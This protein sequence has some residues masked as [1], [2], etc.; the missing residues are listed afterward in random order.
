MIAVPFVYF[1]LLTFILFRRH[2]RIDLVTLISSMFAISGFFSILIDYYDLRYWD[3][4]GYEITTIPAIAYCL[5]LTMCLVP[6][7]VNSN[8]KLGRFKPIK[9]EKIIEIVAWGSTFWFLTTLAFGWD[10]MMH[11]LTG[12]MGDIRKSITEGGGE[13]DWMLS[14]PPLIRLFLSIFNMIF[15]CSWVLIFLAFF[16][17]YVQR[18]SSKYFYLFIFASLSGPFIGIVG[19]DRSKTAYWII[20]ITGMYLLF[21]K[22]M[23]SKE[24]KGAIKMGI[25]IVSILS[26]YLLM[27]TI[28]RFG[29]RDVGMGIGGTEGGIVSYL[30]QNYINFCYFF[31]N[32]E[33]PFTHLGIIFP[34][35]SQYIFGVPSGGTIIQ[36]EM[37]FL[38]HHQTNVFYTFLGHVII[39][40]GKWVAIIFA[41]VY[42]ILS[43]MTLP[44]I[45]RNR[46]VKIS[47]LYLYFAL[48]SVLLLG[49]F[50]HYYTSSILTFS[51]LS[52]FVVVK[53]MEKA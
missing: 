30:G 14:L 15:G 44:K 48:I 32:Y 12:N 19:A 28:S 8:L 34:F 6:F 31:D 29:E 7:V 51:L 4:V 52:M 35:T 42:S 49:I 17:R 3:S 23:T 50:V 37:N 18:M 43:S 47:S 10:S 46:E 2:K 26:L 53:L 13:Q 27:M 36:E 22:T 25:L 1:S 24:R 41:I 21:R 45:C 39:G 38:T 33:P 40:A 5:L 16:S 20:A 11:V 9:N